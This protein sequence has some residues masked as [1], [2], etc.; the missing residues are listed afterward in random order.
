MLFRSLTSTAPDAWRRPLAL[1]LSGLRA[2]PTV[3]PLPEP[4]LTPIQLGAFL[5]NLG[6]HRD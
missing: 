3:T 4:S 6:P 5:S 1:L 2:S